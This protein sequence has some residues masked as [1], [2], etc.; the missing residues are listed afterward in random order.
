MNNKTAISTT[1][2]PSAIGP[3]SQGIKTGNMLFVSGQIAIEPATG[4]ILDDT[5]IQA[6]TNRVLQNMLAVVAAAGGTAENVVRTTVFLKDMQDF[7]EMNAVYAEFF[8]SS[9]PA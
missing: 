9:P 6:Q 1:Q 7:A 5:S 2:A 8:K 3:Y 4:K